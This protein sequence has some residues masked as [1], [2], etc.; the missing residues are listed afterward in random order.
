MPNLKNCHNIADLRRRAK[1]KL[2]APMFNYK[3]GGA[4]DE[5]SF[6]LSHQL[7]LGL[8]RPVVKYFGSSPRR[9]LGRCVEIPGRRILIRMSHN[10]LNL[11]DV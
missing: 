7:Q 9:H 8:C 3:D 4:D 2:P 5:W 1:S 6:G 11:L 10:A